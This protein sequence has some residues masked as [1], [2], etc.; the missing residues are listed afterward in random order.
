[1]EATGFVN[2][3]D[4]PTK[5]RCLQPSEVRSDNCLLSWEHPEDDGG[6]P[7]TGYNVQ[8]LDLEVNEWMNCAETSATSTQVQVTGLKPGHL[9]RFEVVAL[10]K[11]GVSPPAR[12]KEPVMAENPYFAPGEPTDLR[13]VDFDENSVTLRWAKPVNDG[14]RPISH[15]VIQKK[16]EFG[17]WYDALKTDNDN[18]FATIAELEARIPG[19]SLGK[20]YI[21]R[22]IAISKAGESEPSRETKPHLCRYKNLSPAIDKGAGGS[23]TVKVNRLTCFQIKVKGE[24]IPTFAWL[25][26]GQKVESSESLTLSVTH[27]PDDQSAVATL[28]ILRTQ[29]GDAGTYTLIAENRNGSDRVDADLIVLDEVHTNDCEMFLNGSLTCSCNNRFRAEMADNEALKLNAEQEAESMSSKPMAVSVL[30]LCGVVGGMDV[31]LKASCDLQLLT[32]RVSK[33]IDVMFINGGH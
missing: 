5:P 22:V 29:L 19:L 17:G 15:Y 14:G 20:R 27:N 4:I 10:N 28:Q 26:N 25:K 8:L 33:N 1:M 7:I 9:Y 21:F 31:G 30:P 11:E 13:I 24:P 18:C 23:K 3:L 16:D 2:V 6:S 32:Q 12:T